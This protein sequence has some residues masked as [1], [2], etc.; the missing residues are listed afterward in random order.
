[1]KVARGILLGAAAFLL[2]SMGGAVVAA[3]VTLPFLVLAVRSS[4]SARYRLAAAVVAGL[5]TAEVAW[6]LVYVTVGER[7]PTIWLLPL[8]VGVAVL[9]I[10]PLVCRRPTAAAG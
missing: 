3:P 2:L 9:A 4:P 6:A 7:S 10:V 8:L 1:M 5:T